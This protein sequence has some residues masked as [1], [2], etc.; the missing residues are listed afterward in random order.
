[1]RT[2]GDEPE[3]QTGWQAG[4]QA[5]RQARWQHSAGWAMR[6]RRETACTLTGVTSRGG[7]TKRGVVGEA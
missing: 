2:R 7:G 1:M 4:R 3:C 5:G 6:E